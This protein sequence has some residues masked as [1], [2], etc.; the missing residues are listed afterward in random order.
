MNLPPAVDETYTE[1]SEPALPGSTS[2]I[3]SRKT[4]SRTEVVIAVDHQSETRVYTAHLVHRRLG[5][6]TEA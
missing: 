2:Y 3:I 5:A 4:V 6:H 1:I